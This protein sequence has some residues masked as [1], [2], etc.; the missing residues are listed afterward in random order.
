M[1]PMLRV[2]SNENSRAI[3]ISPFKVPFAVGLPAIVCKRPVGF[4]HPVGVFLLP[5][6][7]AG[8]VCRIHNFIG[9]ALLHRLL[10]AQPRVVD[11]PAQSQTGAPVRLHL[12]GHLV[13]GPADARA[14]TSRTGI[15]FFKACSNTSIGSLPVR[16]RMISKA[17]YRIR[18]AFPFFPSIISR[19]ISRVTSLLL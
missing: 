13:V 15:T 12:D 17:S 4:R 2:F 18:W 1:I 8:I 19:L 10:I 11:Q 16:S 6:S 5:H 7:C 14:L 9:Q 3:G